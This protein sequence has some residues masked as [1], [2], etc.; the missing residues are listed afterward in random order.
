VHGTSYIQ[1]VGFDDA[2]PVADAILSYSQSTDPASPHFA[3]QTRAY[4]AKAWHRLPFNPQDIAAQAIS[5]QR[6]IAE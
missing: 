6:Q 4:A 5:N 2:G 3:D 1:I